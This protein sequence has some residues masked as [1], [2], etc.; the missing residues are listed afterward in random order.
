TFSAPIALATPR[1]ET[2]RLFVAEKGGNIR[3][4]TGLAGTPQSSLYL[5]VRTL[6]PGAETLFAEG[7]CG[8]LG[9]AFHPDFASNGEFFVFY[10]FQ[11]T[12]SG[13]NRLF[14]RVARITVPDPAANSAASATLQPLI[15]QY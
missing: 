9:L 13:A 5:N 11:R 12:E 1:G 14:Q 6:L 7:E 2:G 3:V 10:S 8:L 15:T 4:V